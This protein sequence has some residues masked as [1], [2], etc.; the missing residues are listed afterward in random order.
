M[1]LPGKAQRLADATGARREVDATGRSSVVFRAPDDGGSGQAVTASRAIAT[2]PAP[3]MPS[4]QPADT[5]TPDDF[6]DRLLERLRR[7]LLI[8]RERSAGVAFDLY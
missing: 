1:P 6:Y 5:E 8:E 2:A 3:P 4:A 7:D